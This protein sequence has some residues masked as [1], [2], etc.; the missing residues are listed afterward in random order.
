MEYTTEVMGSRM[1]SITEIKVDQ[2][3]DRC[4]G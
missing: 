3:D 2:F 1:A 4:L